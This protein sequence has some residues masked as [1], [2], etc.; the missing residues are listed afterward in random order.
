VL[1]AAQGNY[2]IGLFLVA[3]FGSLAGIFQNGCLALFK[4]SRSR[5]LL[6]DGAEIVRIQERVFQ[7]VFSSFQL[8]GDNFPE[9]GEQGISR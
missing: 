9:S 2:R 6:P 7:P 1:Y 5:D 8:V 3:V 4:C